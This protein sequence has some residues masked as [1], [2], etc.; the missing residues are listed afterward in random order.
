MTSPFNSPLEIGIRSLIIL[1]AAYPRSLDLQFLVFF[2][3]FTVHSGDVQGPDSLHAPLPFRSGEL[4]VKRGL[5]ER[6]L[7]LMVSR[8]LVEHLVSSNG[9]EYRASDNASA[10]LSMLSSPY[11]TQLKER[12]EWVAE[13]FGNSSLH[14]LKEI[15]Q[16]FFRSWSTQ[17]QPLEIPG[18]QR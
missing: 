4:T 10:F 12:A 17:F 7:L 13:A 11:I 3:Y 5:I 9:F 18:R 6:G 8:G 2:D 14:D 15:E 16:S 1:T